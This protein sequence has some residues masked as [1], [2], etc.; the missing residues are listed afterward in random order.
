MITPTFL[1]S[2]PKIG[3][4]IVSTVE[5]RGL[6]YVAT[7]EALYRWDGARDTMECLVFHAGNAA[8]GLPRDPSRP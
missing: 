3:E 5:H 6:L 4:Y 1:W 7:N 8:Y 2:P